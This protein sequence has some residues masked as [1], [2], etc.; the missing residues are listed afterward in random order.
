MNEVFIMHIAI[1]DD[2]AADREIICHCIQ[3]YIEQKIPH[4]MNSIKYFQYSNAETFLESFEANKY[5]IVILDI[6]MT[7]INGM[8]T[9]KIIA[10]TDGNCQIIFLTTSMDHVLDGYTVHAAG[11]VLKPLWKNEE[12][13][14]AA[15]DYCVSKLLLKQ[16][17]FEADIGNTRASVLFHDIYYIDCHN[18]RFA[19]IHFANKDLPT[20]NSYQ[21]CWD[22][23]HQDE[24]F[25]ECYHRIL[26]NM[27][28]IE[29]M[30][31]DTFQMI[32]GRLVP[33]SRR[34]KNEV[35][36]AY[37]LYLTEH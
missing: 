13:F 12:K 34:K 6:Y 18:S 1:V 16:S 27:D 30:N 26:I 4:L 20:H 22:K 35:K 21:Y 25:L 11:Y 17:S 29:T 3:N 15:L 10:S 28:Y 33:I 8:D 32:N 5:D 14:H 19:L 2:N 23:L 9:A 7:K 31:E 37:V 36:H 24:R